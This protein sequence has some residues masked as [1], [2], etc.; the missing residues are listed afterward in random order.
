MEATIRGKENKEH[1]KLTVSRTYEHCVSVKP[2]S[3]SFLISAQLTPFHQSGSMPWS[4]VKPKSYQQEGQ[5]RK[6]EN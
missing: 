2:K 1:S 3:Y 6:T 4:V 5:P